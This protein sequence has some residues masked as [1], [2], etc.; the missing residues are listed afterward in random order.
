M[1]TFVELNLS[2]M[3]YPQ[4]IQIDVNATLHLQHTDVDPSQH[5]TVQV[6]GTINSQPNEGTYQISLD[7]QG[8]D[9][10]FAQIT[11]GPCVVLVILFVLD[12]PDEANSEEEEKR[13]NRDLPSP[14]NFLDLS[15]GEYEAT[16]RLNFDDG[17]AYK[18]VQMNKLSDDHYEA[19]IE[20]A[21]RYPSTKSDNIERILPHDVTITDGGAGTIFGRTQVRWLR[22]DGSILTGDASIEVK[23]KNQYKRLSFPEIFSYEFSHG[24]FSDKPFTMSATGKM[25]AVDTSPKEA[26]I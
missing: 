8:E 25:W 13:A 6:T 26:Q 14:K 19:N 23:L 5:S 20:T 18:N 24:P 15:D 1:N 2:I 16:V 4:N 12:W 9:V 11:S 22:N 3:A 21:H 7:P 10:S 17:Y